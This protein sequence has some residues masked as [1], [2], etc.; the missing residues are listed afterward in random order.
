MPTIKI[1]AKRQATFPSEVCDALGVKPGDSIALE[2][3]VRKGE[4]IWVLK[5]V[6]EAKHSWL[7]SLSKYAR[8]SSRP[9]SRESDGD[10][11]ARAWAEES[12][13]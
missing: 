7:F 3:Q 11:A 12:D 9:W 4:R 6:R 10:A 5:P 1:T 2:E 13:V 8:K